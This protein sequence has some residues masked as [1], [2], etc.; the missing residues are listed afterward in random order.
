M[1]LGVKSLHDITMFT[2]HIHTPKFLTIFAVKLNQR[3]LTS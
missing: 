2:L 1:A 3:Y